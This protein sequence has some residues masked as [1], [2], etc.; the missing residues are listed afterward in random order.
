[1]NLEWKGLTGLHPLLKCK[2][3]KSI[4]RGEAE[5]WR[6]LM[7]GLGLGAVIFQIVIFSQILVI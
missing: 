2:N 5:R 4:L 6:E 7:V 3:K 1:M